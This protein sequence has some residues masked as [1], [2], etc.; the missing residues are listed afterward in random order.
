MG[1]RTH[2]PKPWKPRGQNIPKAKRKPLRKPRTKKLSTAIAWD[3]NELRKISSWSKY[4]NGYNSAWKV[5]AARVRLLS[6]GFKAPGTYPFNQAAG[7]MFSMPSHIPVSFTG[8]EAGWVMRHCANSG[9]LTKSNLEAVRAMLSFAYQLQTGKINVKNTEMNYPEV[10]AQWRSQDQAR[11][12][13]QKRC[14][15]AKVS[16][17]PK[18]LRT[19]F[20]TEW[21][22]DCGIPFVQWCVFEGLSWDMMVCGCRSGNDG[23]LRRVKQ[24]EREVFVPS[25]GYMGFEMLGGRPK[26]PRQQED[27]QWMVY[28]V[29]LCPGGVHKPVPED[30]HM[31]SD[32]GYNPYQVGWCT[33]CPINCRQVVRSLLSDDDR[34]PYPKWNEVGMELGEWNVGRRKMLPA[35]QAWFDAQGANPDGLKY[36]GNSG[37]KSLA[38]WS[39]ELGVPYEQ[40]V[41]LHG[42]LLSIWQKYYQPGVRQS[43][44]KDRFQSEDVDVALAPLRV[45]AQYCGRG[46]TQ[47]KPKPQVNIETLLSAVG[48]KLGIDLS[49]PLL[50]SRF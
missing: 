9:I 44:W 27:R 17:E 1:K 34:R 8:D 32:Q 7:E 38:K 40:S 47:D 35:V 18:D 13:K 28:R 23:G 31:K 46:R 30:W 11:Y 45:F 5:P 6:H 49:Q 48:A 10:Y 25:Q 37:R 20:T 39:Q 3:M 42:D 14:Y 26:L 36:D 12:A 50:P 16:P 4:K 22:P 24:T 41:Q 19:A 15:T 33:S 2:K 21:S 29:C 43:D